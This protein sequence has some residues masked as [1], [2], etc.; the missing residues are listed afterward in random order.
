MDAN[1]SA[2][3]SVQLGRLCWI[4]FTTFIIRSYNDIV[5]N[6]IVTIAPP[7]VMTAL[8]FVV[9]GTLIGR[10]IGSVDGLDYEQYIAPG[11][12]LLPIVTS[13]YSQAGLSLRLEI[14]VVVMLFAVFAMFVLAAALIER[15]VGIRE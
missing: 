11:L 1:R 3:P 7:A 9:F 12:I 14:S 5:Y 10:R 15:G 6:F 2:A 13:S 4:G 8:Y